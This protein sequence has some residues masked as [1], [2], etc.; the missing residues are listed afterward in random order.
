M[1]AKAER[2]L[3][4]SVNL[5]EIAEHYDALLC[6]LWGVVHDGHAL[7]PGAL[8]ALQFLRKRG[9]KP[10]FISNAPRRSHMVKQKLRE[11]G[12]SDDMY[13]D[14]LTSGET[15]RALLQSGAFAKAPVHYMLVAE[16]RDGDIC[17]GLP[18]FDRVHSVEAA[19]LVVI[20][21]YPDA[22]RSCDAILPLLEKLLAGNKT[23][24]CANPDKYV[25]RLEGKREQCAGCIADAYRAMGGDVLEVGKPF[26]DI[27]KYALERYCKSVD[28][29]RVA[30]IGDNMDTDVR[31]AVDNGMDA[32]LVAGGMHAAEIEEKGTASFLR[33]YSLLPT[34]ILPAFCAPRATS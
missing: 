18:G 16:R 10:V 3:P 12:V 15:L 22:A 31:G 33:S 27:Y 11:L 25:V 23:V 20:A 26:S 14:V 21:G 32:Y 2:A 19:N 30:C 29:R 17:D 28:K 1:M 6:D 13:L 8:D 5:E 4:R 24:I 7:Y 34:G 9:V